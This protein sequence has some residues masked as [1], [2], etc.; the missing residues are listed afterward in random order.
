MLDQGAGERQRLGANGLV[1]LVQ[2]L[3]KCTL[4]G[5]ALAAGVMELLRP[6]TTPHAAHAGEEFHYC[7]SGRVRLALGGRLYELARGHA[8]GCPLRVPNVRIND[9]NIRRGK[10]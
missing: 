2:K 4:H 1:V 5:G 3:L 6:D 7:L 9:E 10:L 8:A